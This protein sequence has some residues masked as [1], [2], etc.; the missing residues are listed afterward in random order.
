MVGLKTREPSIVDDPFALFGEWQDAAGLTE[1][2]DP[3]AMAVATVD[4]SGLPDLRM[5]LCKAHD[6]DGFVFYTNFESAKGRELHAHPKAAALF[7]WKTQR[8]QIRI[9][10][11]VEV[12]SDAEADA[13]FTSRPRGSRI[14][15][16]AS[17]QSRPIGSRAELEGAVAVVEARF[18][19]ET[20]PR[21]PHW[22]GFRIRPVTI[23]FW[24]DGAYRLHDRFLYA[25]PEPA[26]A[27]TAT[28][29]QP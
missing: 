16:W 18:P 28:R 29:L 26:G 21:P 24:S 7:H 17:A 15:A 10:G 20:V 25:R 3:T 14:G 8:R 1:P 2:N 9:R 27:W 13:Y 12:V 4:E 11:P 6:A 5:V 23:E 19:G 22:S